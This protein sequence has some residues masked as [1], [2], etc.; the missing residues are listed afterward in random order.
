MRV[1]KGCSESLGLTT[2]AILDPAATLSAREQEVHALVCEGLTNAEIGR[3]LFIAESTVKAHTASVYEKL[4]VHSRK[5]LMLN[6]RAAWLRDANRCSRRHVGRMSGG[7]ALGQQHRI[8]SL[9]H[10]GS[11]P[12][13]R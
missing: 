1:T 5:A 13:I 2:A 10:S 3:R 4:G 11:P 12:D 9:G 6:A 8:R 7:D